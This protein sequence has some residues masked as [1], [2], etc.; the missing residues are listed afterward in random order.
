MQADSG[1]GL[2]IQ[3]SIII[4]RG[5]TVGQETPQATGWKRLP[6]AVSFITFMEKIILHCWKL[7]QGWLV[8]IIILSPDCGLA[9]EGKSNKRRF[10]SRIVGGTETSEGEIP[11]QVERAIYYWTSS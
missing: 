3:P 1:G 2:P 4:P 6:T 10:R 11:W 7:E 5:W 8:P 9:S